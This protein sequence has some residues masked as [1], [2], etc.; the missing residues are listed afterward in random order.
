MDRLKEPCSL[1][2]FSQ[3]FVLRATA[4]CAI[5]VPYTLVLEPRGEIWVTV[6]LR[7]RD[8]MAIFVDGIASYIVCLR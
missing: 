1:G 4:I 7:E 3:W 2:E 8:G 6:T 5:Y